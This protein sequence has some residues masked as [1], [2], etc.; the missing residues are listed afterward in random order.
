VPIE[1]HSIISKIEHYH[2]LLRRAYNIISAELGASVDRD[3]ILQMAIKAINDTISPDGIVPTVLIFGV[4][5]R[6][7]I[8]SP[9]SALTARRA[10]TMR[11]AIV[12]LRRI[13]AKRR[14]NDALNTRNSPIVTETLSLAPRSDIKVWC[15]GAG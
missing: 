1:A 4:Y 14:V 5:P 7:T 2:A 9:P 10:E 6:M 15:E 8:N 11:K 12:D 13:V 3:V